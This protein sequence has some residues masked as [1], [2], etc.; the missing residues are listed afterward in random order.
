LLAA[1][2]VPRTGKI[3][4]DDGENLLTKWY[5]LEFTQVKKTTFRKGA[6]RLIKGKE[7]DYMIYELQI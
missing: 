4:K 2:V 1:A 6:W 3:I 5:I 7:G